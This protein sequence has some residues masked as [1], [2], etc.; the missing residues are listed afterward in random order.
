MISFAEHNGNFTAAFKNIF[1]W[2]SRID[3][4]VFQGKPMVMLSTSVG[5]GGAANVLRI[6]T[7]SAPHFGGEVRASLSIGPF[8]EK[9]NTQDGTLSDAELAAQ[10]RETL[11]ALL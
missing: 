6:A 11:R 10:L 9:F 5:K 3:Q 1:D 7:T 2:A 4:K 8:H